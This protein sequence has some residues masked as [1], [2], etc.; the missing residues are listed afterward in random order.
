MRREPLT[1]AFNALES[2]DDDL[3]MT[4]SLPASNHLNVCAQNVASGRLM[5]YTAG[6]R[7]R[8]HDN[9]HLR[10]GDAYRR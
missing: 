6:V 5:S 3:V 10:P 4:P 8:F 7:P 2:G 1:F 9:L